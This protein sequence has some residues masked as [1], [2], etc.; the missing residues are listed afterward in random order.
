[1]KTS[2]VFEENINNRSKYYDNISEN[3]FFK[4]TSSLDPL[5]RHEKNISLEKNQS[6]SEEIDMTGCDDKL[7][8]VTEENDA[9]A[10]VT[11]RGPLRMLTHNNWRDVGSDDGVVDIVLESCKQGYQEGEQ[12]LRIRQKKNTSVSDLN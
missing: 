2:K 6:N 1:M 11:K 3:L 9:K 7:L 5:S 12:R 4:N 8:N 10:E